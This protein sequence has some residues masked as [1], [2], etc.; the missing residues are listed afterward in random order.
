MDPMSP[1]QETIDY[2][3][4]TR[5]LNEYADVVSRQS[6]D[7][8]VPLFDPDCRIR[9]DLIQSV[10]DYTGPR[11]IGQLIAGAAGQFEFFQFVI[12]DAVIR[13]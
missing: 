12:L 3:A 2:V 13:I 4:I 8:L 10:R 11:E 1:A 7:E 5:L 9:L 6:W